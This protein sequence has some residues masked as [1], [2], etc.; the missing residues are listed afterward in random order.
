VP[1]IPLCAAQAPALVA[2]LSLHR[3]PNGQ[4]RLAVVYTELRIVH[5]VDFYEGRPQR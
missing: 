3:F 2:K 5:A 4:S 1:R